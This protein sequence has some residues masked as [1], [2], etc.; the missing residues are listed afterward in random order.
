MVKQGR[1][2]GREDIGAETWRMRRVQSWEKLRERHSMQREQ[3]I[4]RPWRETDLAM[5]KKQEKMWVREADSG[6][7]WIQKEFCGQHFRFSSIYNGREEGEWS[8]A[9]VEGLWSRPVKTIG[10]RGSGRKV[11]DPQEKRPQW[12]G[13]GWGN[14]DGDKWINLRY[15]SENKKVI[16]RPSCAII[17]PLAEALA[18]R[19]LQRKESSMRML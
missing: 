1:T 8:M 18:R 9:S 16:Q 6:T 10:G 7:R 17:S 4:Q 2:F 12:F 15:I 5:L 3:Q 19:L 11:H 13:L 14:G